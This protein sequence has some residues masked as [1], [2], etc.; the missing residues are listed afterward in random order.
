MMIQ[1]AIQKTPEPQTQDD[2]PEEAPEGGKFPRLKAVIRKKRH[3]LKRNNTVAKFTMT[4]SGCIKIGMLKKFMDNGV[5][6]NIDILYW[7]APD[8]DLDPGMI[9]LVVDVLLKLAE[10]GVQI[11]LATNNCLFVRYLQAR[12]DERHSV[13]YHSLYADKYA[14]C[15]I[16]TSGTRFSRIKETP[17]ERDFFHLIDTISKSEMERPADFE[18]EEREKEEEAEPEMPEPPLSSKL[19]I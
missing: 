15:S 7:D 1:S 10:A 3:C 13:R 5:L 11:F 2:A 4:S 14:S 8:A 12:T 18:E 19:R 9:P 16:C 6:D 17:I